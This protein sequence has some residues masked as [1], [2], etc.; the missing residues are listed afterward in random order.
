[1]NPNPGMESVG[2]ASRCY[3]ELMAFEISRRS[4]FQ[5]LGISALFGLSRA[6]GLPPGSEQVTPFH[7]SGAGGYLLNSTMI[8]NQFL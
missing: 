1:M 4:I 8:A 3:A 7:G 2:M 5:G 6:V